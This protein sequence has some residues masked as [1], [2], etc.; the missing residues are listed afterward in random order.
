MMGRLARKLG[1]LAAIILGLA[2]LAP[3][4][5]WGRT[6]ELVPYPLPSVWP[7]AVRYLRVNRD[8][9]IREKDESAGYILFDYTD[10]PKSCKASLE[11]IRVTDGEGR[12]AT[13]LAVSIPELPHRYEQMLLDKL[14]TK[15]R[16]DIGPPPPPRKP[17][18]PKPDAGPPAPQPP[19]SPQQQEPSVF[20]PTP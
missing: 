1:P 6:L 4:P 11:L 17:E 9:P 2:F 16:D 20:R 7:A 5:G 8:F 15:L 3:S 19:P 12:D 14:A 10:G 13:R 18:P